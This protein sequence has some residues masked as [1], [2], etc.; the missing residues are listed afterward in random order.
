MSPRATKHQPPSAEQVAE[1]TEAV[2]TLT[3][4][5]RCLRISV[6]EIEQELGWAIRS[7]VLEHL[8]RPEFPCDARLELPDVDER[9]SGFEHASDL[10]DELPEPI[11]APSP[12]PF[13]LS[14]RQAKLW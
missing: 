14:G 9:L 4:Q 6:D 3:D 13:P 11:T 1:L 8:P 5:V 7:K 12:I 2:L 10:E